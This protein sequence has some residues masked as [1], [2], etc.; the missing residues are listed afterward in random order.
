[1]DDLGSSAAPMSNA[2]GAMAGV[3]T[4]VGNAVGGVATNFGPLL[5]PDTE[6]TD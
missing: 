1:M 5:T 2:S 3:G 4:V 6:S